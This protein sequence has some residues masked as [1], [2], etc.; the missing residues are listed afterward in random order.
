MV[1]LL[2]GTVT[3]SQ[4]V[5]QAI[6]ISGM[7]N[8]VVRKVKMQ[9]NLFVVLFYLCVRACVRVCKGLL[10]EM[11]ID[12]YIYWSTVFA[13]LIWLQDVTI[14]LTELIVKVWVLYVLTCLYFLFVVVLSE[15]VHWS[16]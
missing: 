14:G 13:F 8:G 1:W 4:M 15:P 12:I 9:V 5:A 7:T 16:K 2:G 3:V 6:G 11:S 10:A